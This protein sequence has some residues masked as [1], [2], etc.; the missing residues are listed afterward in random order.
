MITGYTLEASNSHSEFGEYDNVYSPFP[1]SFTD[2][3]IS[4]ELLSFESNITAGFNKKISSSPS[5][6]EIELSSLTV[7]PNH[8]SLDNNQF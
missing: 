2:K 3:E 8:L 6:N 7:S 1:I 5:S 4:Y